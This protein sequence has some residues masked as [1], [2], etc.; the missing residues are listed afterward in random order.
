M[1]VFLKVADNT[2]EVA[3]VALENSNIDKAYDLEVEDEVSVIG[4]VG[5]Y[6]NK[7]E[8]IAKEILKI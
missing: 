7:I 5:E 1:H 6:K 8:I 4:R 3:V 2:G